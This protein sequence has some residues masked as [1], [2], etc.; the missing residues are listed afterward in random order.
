MGTP[1]QGGTVALAP[2]GTHVL[3]TPKAGFTGQETFTYTIR[4]RSGT[5]GLTDTATVTVT[6][7]TKNK[8]TVVNDT[9]TVEEDSTLNTINVLAN[10]TPFTSGATLT[11]TAVTQSAKGGTVAIGANGANVRYTPAPNFFGTDTFTYTVSEAGAG[12]ATGTVTLTVTGKNDLP[13][14]AD[15]EFSLLKNGGQQT[16]DVLK[17]D[18]ILPDADETLTIKEITQPTSGGTVAIATDKKSLLF[19]PTTGFEGDAT[20][21]YV[22]D[23]GN[24]GTDSAT[25]TV[26]VRQYTPRDIGGTATYDWAET[27]PV[28]GWKLDLTGT[29]SYNHSVQLSG[30]T[31]ADGLFNF[32]D[33]A[34]GSYT[35]KAAST[36]FLLPK[37]VELTVNSALSDGDSTANKL[38]APG[39]LAQYVSP[40]DFLATAPRQSSVSPAHAL[41]VAATSGTSQ[42]WYTVESGWQNYRSLDV[43]LSQDLKSLKVKAVDNN[44]KT[45][46]AAVPTNSAQRVVFLG[47][48]GSNYLLQIYGG[49]ADLGLKEV[50]TTSSSSTSRR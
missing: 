26:H 14:A 19:T 21:T 4:D 49:A 33:L 44:A 40:Y 16:L 43:A 45:Y 3:Y 7:E 30:L 34:P 11:V 38:E 15:D 18:S 8:P 24:N 25:V 27:V 2:N 22:A 31:G 5:D 6:V 32:A 28:G 35:V 9:A 23:D 48:E 39:R 46:Q 13:T 12:N 20:F 42:Q 17:N 36:P 47:H 41:T 29:D 37:T 50:T 1:S 10:D